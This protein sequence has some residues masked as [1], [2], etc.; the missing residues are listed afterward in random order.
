[1]LF[2]EEC[3][4]ELSI[5]ADEEFGIGNNALGVWLTYQRLA[6]PLLGKQTVED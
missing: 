6:L 3:N 2:V 4:D 5:G 1:M